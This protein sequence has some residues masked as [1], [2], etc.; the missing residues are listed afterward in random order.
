MKQLLLYFLFFVGSAIIFIQCAKLFPTTDKLSKRQPQSQN[1]TDFTSYI[2][3]NNSTLLQSNA[4]AFKFSFKNR[5]IKPLFYGSFFPYNMM[6]FIDN[7]PLLYNRYVSLHYYDIITDYPHK[8][9]R[10]K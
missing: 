1:K 6:V 3:K 9:H 5:V 4:S 8:P 2:T 7:H 10:N